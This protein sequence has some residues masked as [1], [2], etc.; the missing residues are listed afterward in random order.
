[1]AVGWVDA[2]GGMW[3]KDEQID[4]AAL[5]K[6]WCLRT[7]E[8][9]GGYRDSEGKMGAKDRLLCCLTGF[10]DRTSVSIIVFLP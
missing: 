2:V 9:G 5:E 8:T 7:F 4:F 3:V 6:E 10:E 1:M